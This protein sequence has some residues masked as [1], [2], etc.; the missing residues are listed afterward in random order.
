[1]QV[2][3]IIGSLE[4]INAIVG[5]AGSGKTTI[6]NNVKKLFD[7]IQVYSMDYR[8]IGNGESRK[9]LLQKKSNFSLESYQDACNQQ[10]WWDWDKIENDIDCL[11]NGKN[12]VIEN[13]YDRDTGLFKEI[14]ICAK[15][16]IICEGAILG[17]HWIINKFSKILFLATDPYIRLDRLINK[18]KNRRTITEI[19]A[20]F[21]ITEYSENMHYK[22]LFKYYEDKIICIGN[23]KFE[24]LQ[25]IPIMI[26]KSK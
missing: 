22:N 20:R 25:Y 15:K 8:L 21:L 17:P 14:N 26:N 11:K 16:N 3:D 1:M 18:D 2:I 7:E 19:I 6:A 12:I 10:N 23:Y 9:E 24:N 13:A 4:G 5:S